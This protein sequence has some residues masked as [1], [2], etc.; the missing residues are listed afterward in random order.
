MSTVMYIDCCYHNI[1]IW[2]K[3]DNGVA[4]LF[5]QIDK[6]CLTYVNTFQVNQWSFRANRRSGEVK[7]LFQNNAFAQ[8]SFKTY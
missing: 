4:V 8:T 2:T 1:Y 7:E 6:L 5:R 3:A